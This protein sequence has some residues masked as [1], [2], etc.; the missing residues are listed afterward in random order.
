MTE[1]YKQVDGKFVS[2]GMEFTGFPVNGIWVVEDGHRN[3]IYQFKE[4]VPE[5]PSPALL[6]Y[7]ILQDELTQVIQARWKENALSVA[8]IANIACEFFAI[9]A[10]GLKVNGEIVEY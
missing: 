8:G 6:S 7:M 5:M 4:P 3:C 2:V 1:L 10:G 9:K